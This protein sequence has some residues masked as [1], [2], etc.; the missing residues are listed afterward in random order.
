MATVGNDALDLSRSVMINAE[1]CAEHDAAM[2]KIA[3]LTTNQYFAA[4]RKRADMRAFDRFPAQTG[5]EPP[6]PDDMVPS[7]W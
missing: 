7:D 6:R 4:R 3:A 5:G 2:E 1:R